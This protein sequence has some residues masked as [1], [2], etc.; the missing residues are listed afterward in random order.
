M[1]DELITEALKLQEH[2]MLRQPLS[3]ALNLGYSAVNSLGDRNGRNPQDY[4]SNLR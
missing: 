2:S 4:H 3:T 1:I